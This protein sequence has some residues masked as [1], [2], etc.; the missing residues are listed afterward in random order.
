[1]LASIEIFI[2]VYY[3]LPFIINAVI[4]VVVVVIIIACFA[5]ITTASPS[6][7]SISSPYFFTVLALAN[8]I[9]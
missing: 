7:H 8:G 2:I 1:M 5:V 6:C 4:V 9:K 3:D